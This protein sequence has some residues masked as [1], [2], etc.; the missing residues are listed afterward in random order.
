M[1]LLRRFAVHGAGVAAVPTL[2]ALLDDC[3]LVRVSLLKPSPRLD[4][5][6]A[7]G[8]R[9]SAVRAEAYARRAGLPVLR[10]EDGFLR[11]LALGTDAP[12]LSIVLDDLGIYFDA[13]R[14]SRLESL[15][16]AGAD[17][18][19]CARAQNLRSLWCAA[20]VSK[21]NHARDDALS[22]ALPARYVLVVD[23]TCGDAS[24]RG[25]LADAGAFARMLSAALANHPD[26]RVLLKVHP[27]VVSGRKRGHFDMAQIACTPR[28]QVVADA[29]HP[30]PLLERAEA[31]YTVTSQLGF[32]ALLHGKP[33]Y[34]FGMPFYAGWG[35]THDALPAPAR[36]HPVSLDQLMH[37]A[38]VAYPRY[39]D[40]E[41]GA[42]CEVET[43]LAWLALQRRAAAQLPARI[44]ALGFAP[45]K[46]ATLRRFLAG[47]D[48]I[49]RRQHPGVPHDATVAVWGLGVR[50]NHAARTLCIEDGFLRSVGLGAGLVEPLSWVVDDVGVYYDATR[51]SRLEQILEHGEIDE[52]LRARAATLRERICTAGLT[53]YN[54]SGTRWQRPAGK[55]RV[56][57]VPGQVES[58]ASIVL[59]APGIRENMALLRAVRE[60]NPDAWLVYKPHP[61][62]VAGLRRSGRGE[63]GASAYCD[64]VVVDAPMQDL[65][66]SVDELHVLTSLAGFEALL[67]G[68]PVTCWGQPFYAGWGLTRDQL[69]LARRTRQRSLDELVAAALILYPRYVSRRSGALTT[70]ERALTELVSWREEQSPATARATTARWFMR[71]RA[72]VLRR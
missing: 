60:E 69:P 48:L 16:L 15:V 19:A 40:P 33:V 10:I 49:F 51:P 39:L 9:P 3:E 47:S 6:L 44:H 64:E 46:R 66:A 12:P 28:V 59:G 43:L 72:A 27:D 21:Y 52:P 4:G 34:T 62:V 65:L 31:V 53:K 26:C 22:Q 70:P 23:Q 5:V 32:E 67:R 8:Y 68:K 18:A 25:G 50:P 7:W 35:L 30:V 1:N 2:P 11:S 61:D 13:S 57:L 20:R 17:D 55:A 41:T 38:L 29:V 42:R 54:L 37:A 45:W 58:D 14:P 36:R 71:V 24:I 63:A 56:I